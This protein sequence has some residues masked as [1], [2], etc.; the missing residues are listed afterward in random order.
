MHAIMHV[1]AYA[2]ITCLHVCIHACRSPAYISVVTVTNLHTVTGEKRKREEES[3]KGPGQK[4]KEREE[5]EDEEDDEDGGKE[6]GGGG[7]DREA[8]ECNFTVRADVD[9]DYIILHQCKVCVY[10]VQEKK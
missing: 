5:K 6:G 7:L 3:Q 8:R 10:I 9:T 4:D 2:C 1:R